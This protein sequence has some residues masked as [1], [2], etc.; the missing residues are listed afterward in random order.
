MTSPQ[1]SGQRLREVLARLAPELRTRSSTVSDDLQRATDGAELRVV[2]ALLELAVA[3]LSCGIGSYPES[4]VALSRTPLPGR[5]RLALPAARLGDL[6]DLALT[7]IGSA[8]SLRRDLDAKI[9]KLA[10]FT[11]DSSVNL[12]D[13]II[14]LRD[15]ELAATAEV[16][17]TV[18]SHVRSVSDALL[19]CLR[20]C[21]GLLEGT[22]LKTS[23]A[24]SKSDKISLASA[25]LAEISLLLSAWLEWRTSEGVPR[26]PAPKRRAKLHL[27]P[28]LRS[29]CVTED[30]AA[31]LVRLIRLS[32]RMRR[33]RARLEAALSLIDT[34]E[35]AQEIV[36]QLDERVVFV[37]PR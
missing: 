35:I 7:E 13:H 23:Q 37:P 15:S 5:P 22:L 14:S 34:L 32:F 24:T 27:S 31:E 12:A 16:E 3:A 19:T 11:S 17:D 30:E 33:T 20:S 10:L 18:A 36:T 8:T 1:S 21:S 28:E 6:R 9:T 2:L 4:R 26:Q 25:G 29:A